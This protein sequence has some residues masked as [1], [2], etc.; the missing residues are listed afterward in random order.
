MATNQM[1][2]QATIEQL[3]LSPVL[4]HYAHYET[5]LSMQFVKSMQYQVVHG[6]ILE[7][8]KKVNFH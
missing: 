6:I 8:S 5:V 1:D 3:I 4:S 2:I 7:K